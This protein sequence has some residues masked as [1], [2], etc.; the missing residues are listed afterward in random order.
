[1]YFLLTSLQNQLEKTFDQNFI[2]IL[3]KYDFNKLEDGLMEELVCT[4]LKSFWLNKF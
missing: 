4:I 1:M 3:L 2:N